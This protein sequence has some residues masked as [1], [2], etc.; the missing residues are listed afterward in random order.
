MSNSI[1]I[2]QHV[3]EVDSHRAQLIDGKTKPKVCYLIS[4]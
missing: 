1:V 4:L 3:D 2:D